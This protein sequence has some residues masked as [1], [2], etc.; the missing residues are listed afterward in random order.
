MKLLT[1]NDRRGEHAP[2]WY[3]AS[4]Q[5]VDRPPL[6]R[7][8][9]A[10]VCVI[11]AGFTGLATALELANNG[12]GVVVLDAHRVGWGASGRNG[13][14]LGSGFNKTPPELE[15]LV[16]KLG[17]RALWQIAEDAKTHI[18]KICKLHGI[19]IDYKPGIVYAQHRQ[20]NVQAAHE[21]CDVMARDYD[22]HSLEPLTR[23][24]IR[25]L[26]ASDNYHGGFVDHGAGHIHPL[27]MA[28]GLAR[29]AESA[30][31]IIHERSEVV[32]IQP[33]SGGRGQRIITATGAVDCDKVVI[34]T[35]GYL[36]NL[37]PSLNK[38]SMPINNFIVVTEPLGERAN[39]LLPQ[40]NAVADSR[41]VVN[42]F[43]RVDTD[44]LLF[45]G[46]ENYSYRFPSS[47]EATV[48]RA[49]S[50]VFPQ[51]HD[52]A[53]D[54]A[55]GGTLAITRK[56]LPYLKLVNRDVYAAGGYSGHGLALAV[57]YG[58]AIAE[59][60]DHRSD[61]FDQLAALPAIAFPGGTR[62]RPVLLATAM[63]VYS[64]LDRI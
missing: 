31:A 26:V 50:G 49:M 42:Y 4:C 57:M 54:Y 41:F 35:N 39:S 3:Q 30:G 62:S 24:S 8:V 46:G 51:L 2:S 34:A 29:A 32:R 37:Q 1:A 16:G 27:K 9:S 25:Q 14:Q 11:G 36:D 52:V 55:W 40:D 44:R 45:G 64:W 60:I 21:Y 10:E 6:E 53:I 33:L 12:H 18:R 22:Y 28:M 5:A 59:H 13:G 43:R 63:T 58:T 38:W 15:S 48:R 61:R 17:A 23:S 20:R 56:R 47:I 7:T 19:D